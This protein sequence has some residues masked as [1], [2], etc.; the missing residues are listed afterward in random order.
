MHKKAL[1]VHFLRIY[2]T[3]NCAIKEKLPYFANANLRIK[4]YLLIN[5]KKLCLK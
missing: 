1:F 4:F 5:N 3:K 2:C